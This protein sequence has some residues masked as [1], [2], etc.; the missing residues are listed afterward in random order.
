MRNLRLEVNAFGSDEEHRQNI[1]A[2]LQ[3]GLPELEMLP[4]HED[5]FVLVG[6]G[7]SMP[8][9][10][11][12]IRKESHICAVKGAHDFLVGNGILPSYYIN[13]DPRD[14]RHQLTLANDVT[15][16]YL[17]SR[18]MPEMFACLKGRDVRIFHC[19]HLGV[20]NWPEFAGKLM[21]Q[22]GTTSGLRGINLGFALGYRKFKLYGFDSCLA[23]D[24]LTKRFTGE[25]AVD[26]VDIIVGGRIFYA[27]AA[28]AQQA[29]DWKECL[30]RYSDH[31]EF[32]VV[33]N[34]LLA[35]INREW[36]RR[37]VA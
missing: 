24:R 21:L 4:Q 13:I 10:L 32:E 23:P 22:G 36:R 33:G 28:M 19:Y 35:T 8:D 12:D 14:R 7:P 5:T 34:G 1:N 20:E 15:R 25:Q 37:K 18:C 2:N 31:C 3:L 17:A 9:F 29:V 26:T 6:S 30:A 16:Y 27:N 11:E